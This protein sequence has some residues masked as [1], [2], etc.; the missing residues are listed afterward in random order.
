MKTVEFYE[1]VI[2]L[3]DAELTAFAEKELAKY[4]KAQETRKVYAE[5]KAAEK[6][7]QKAEIFDKVFAVLT[8]EPKTATTLVEEAG[9]E[10]TRQAIPPLFKAFGEGKVAK[11]EMKVDGAKGKQV[12]YVKA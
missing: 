2:A 10:I 6:K 7:A 9:V 8:D 12:G 11:V 1:K 3:G 4:A 5:K